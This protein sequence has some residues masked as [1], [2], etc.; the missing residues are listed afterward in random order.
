MTRLSDFSPKGT[1]LSA[2]EQSLK[3]IEEGRITTYKSVDD[4]YQKMGLQEEKKKR[5]QEIIDELVGC[6][7]LPEDFDYKKEL[8]KAIC[9]RYL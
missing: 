2:Y 4:F 6:V 9:E 1:T 7:S 5:K 3:D 8:K